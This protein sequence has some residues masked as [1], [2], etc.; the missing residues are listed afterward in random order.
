MARSTIE[1]TMQAARLQVAALLL[2]AGLASAARAESEW[3]VN[4]AAATAA[5][6]GDVAAMLIA[7]GWA[8]EAA[9]RPDVSRPATTLDRIVDMRS[10]LERLLGVSADRAAAWLE[11]GMVAT[12]GWMECGL[13]V[14]ASAP[15]RDAAS[16]PGDEFVS[17]LERL[18][19]DAGEPVWPRVETVRAMSSAMSA[20]SSSWITEPE[21]TLAVVQSP[22]ATPTPTPRAS[23]PAAGVSTEPMA[24]LLPIMAIAFGVFIVFVP[25]IA[26]WLMRGA[27]RP[28]AT[29][30]EMKTT[31]G[32]VAG[33][34]ETRRAA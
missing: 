26:M 17:D 18:L 10:D 8:H 30:T 2:A 23:E 25:A 24:T 16:R 31:A 28:S 7:A 32:R 3:A 13:Y 4:G 15:S 14:D 5:V 1:L 9:P 6:Q 19:L 12:A 11:R 27:A 20:D 21:I 33:E 29:S 34:V 22:L